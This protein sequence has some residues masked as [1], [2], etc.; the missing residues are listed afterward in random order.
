MIMVLL[1][2]KIVIFVRIFSFLL[3]FKNGEDF[4]YKIFIIILIFIK[5]SEDFYFKIF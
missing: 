2:G 3:Y 1:L 5:N 4:G